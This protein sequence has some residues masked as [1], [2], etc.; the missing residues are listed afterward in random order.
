L[1]E[2][3]AIG[4]WEVAAAAKLPRRMARQLMTGK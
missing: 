2:P 1:A 4:W 3:L